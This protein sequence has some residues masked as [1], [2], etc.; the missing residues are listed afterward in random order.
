MTKKVYVNT[1]GTYVYSSM[2]CWKLG[3]IVGKMHDSEGYLTHY[4]VKLEYNHRIIRARISDVA[5]VV[6]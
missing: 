3:E 5:E 1:Q 4:L 6:E 2:A